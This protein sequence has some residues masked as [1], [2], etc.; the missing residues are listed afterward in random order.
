MTKKILALGDLHCGHRTGLTPPHWQRDR[1]QEES[2][3]AYIELVKKAGPVDLVV[4]NGD[5]VDGKNTRA[6]GTELLV[7]DRHEQGDM[8]VKCIEEIDCSNIV[9]TFGTPYHTGIEEDFESPVARSLGAKIRDVLEFT[10]EGVNF[11]VKHKIGSS[12]IP[13]GRQ[14]PIAKEKMWNLFWEEIGVQQKGNIFIRSHVHYYTFC[15]GENWLGITLPALQG[16]G[17][18]Y[19]SRQCSGIVNFG[20]VLFAVD[21]GRWAHRALSKTLKKQVKPPLQF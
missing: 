9:M 10:I 8:A 17:S 3:E 12:T 20:M 18:K 16:F 13:H 7:A 11:N 19:G 21:N 15:G 5:S 6:G 14:T 2:W 4:I 1:K